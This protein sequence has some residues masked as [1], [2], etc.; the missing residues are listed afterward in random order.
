MSSIPPESRVAIRNWSGVF[1]GLQDGGTVVGD[2][3]ADLGQRRVVVR[4]EG[5]QG[6]GAALGGPVGAEEPVLEIER[7]FGDDRTAVAG[8]RRSRWP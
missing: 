1:V 3:D 8:L 6:L 5:A 7:H 4:T 2:V